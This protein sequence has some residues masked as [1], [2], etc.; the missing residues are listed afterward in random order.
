MVEKANAACTDELQCVTTVE[1]HGSR[2]K[3]LCRCHELGIEQVL[4]PVWPIHQYTC[5]VG[6]T[7]NAS[8]I[9]VG[10]ESDCAT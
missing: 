7:V 4:I 3:Y 1:D 10:Y 6:S 8:D 2:K 9:L 5:I